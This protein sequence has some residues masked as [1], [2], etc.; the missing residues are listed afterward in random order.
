MSEIR[1]GE[2]EFLR[3]WNELVC[4]ESR[5]EKP[6]GPQ[7]GDVIYL[8]ATGESIVYDAGEPA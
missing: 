3:K 6:E 2:A 4:E 5:R 7:P 8:Y 1:L